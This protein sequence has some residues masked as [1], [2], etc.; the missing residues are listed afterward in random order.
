MSHPSYFSKRLP[1]DVGNQYRRREEY[2]P[3]LRSHLHL[4]PPEPE[5]SNP[6]TGDV[7]VN[8]EWMSKEEYKSRYPDFSETEELSE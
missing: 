2:D 7:K 6:Y 3:V 5:D 1:G 4:K 8:G